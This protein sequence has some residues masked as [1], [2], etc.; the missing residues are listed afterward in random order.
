MHHTI[1]KTAQQIFILSS[2][3]IG[4]KIFTSFMEILLWRGTLPKTSTL[5]KRNS[6]FV[7]D[8]EELK[9]KP[10]NGTTTV[11]GL[12]TSIHALRSH[13]AISSQDQSR[14]LSRFH[15]KGSEKV[16]RA[17]QERLL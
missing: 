16:N 11:S 15:L 17:G 10:S 7:L 9:K 5:A 14:R 3:E 4:V 13:K 12:G 6:S 1:V 2:N 8:L